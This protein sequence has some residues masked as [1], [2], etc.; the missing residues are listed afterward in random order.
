[1]YKTVYV[2]SVVFR[3]CAVERNG[4]HEKY[5]ANSLYASNVVLFLGK[6]VTKRHGIWKR[7]TTFTT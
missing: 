2:H 4:S 7:E 3:R 5:I 1:V 6:S